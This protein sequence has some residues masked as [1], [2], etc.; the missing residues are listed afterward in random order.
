M[1][2]SGAGVRAGTV[3]RIEVLSAAVGCWSPIL[4]SFQEPFHGEHTSTFSVIV[5]AW[6]CSFTGC[7]SIIK[8]V[9]VFTGSR[10]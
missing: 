4:N 7:L 1:L 6:D 10:R 9:F 8:N 2:V 5:N 3:S